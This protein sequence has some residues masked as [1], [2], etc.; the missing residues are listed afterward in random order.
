MFYISEQPANLKRE[1][2]IA[3]EGLIYQ[4]LESFLPGMDF[5]LFFPRTTPEN[6]RQGD[7]YIP[8]V[9]KDRALLPLVQ[10]KHLLGIVV[11]KKKTDGDA[12]PEETVLASALHL[13]VEN[14]GL[15]KAGETDHLTGLKNSQTFLS[16]I[17]RE[18]EQ[19]SAGLESGPN[20]WPENGS[21]A[22]FTVLVAD[23]DNLQS[24]NNRYSFSLGDEALVQAAECIRSLVPQHA[25]TARLDGDD[26]MAILLPNTRSRDCR[27]LA[28]SIIS[29]IQ[30][31]QLRTPLTQERLR[32]SGSIG[33]ASFPQ[34]IRG[35]RA[36]KG[37]MEI[38][39]QILEKAKTTLEYARKQGKNYCTFSQIL[40]NGAQI[41][42][43]LSLGRALI[44]IGHLTG[45][46]E[47][48]RFQV[49]PSFYNNHRENGAQ[50]KSKAQTFSPPKAE[51]ML[52]DVQEKESLAEILQ[53]NDP[54]WP[55]LQGD[56]L[57]L[58]PE[59]RELSVPEN[60]T[61]TSE[62][63][64]DSTTGLYTL[65]SFLHL[66][67]SLKSEYP[68]FSLIL[69]RIGDNLP[70]ADSKDME[71]EQIQC[72]AEKIRKDFPEESVG[73][74]YGS[75]SLIFLVPKYI[76]RGL[77][78]ACSALEKF[79][80]KDLNGQ[81][82][83]GIAT[84]PFLDFSRSAT[85]HNVR[86]ALEHSLLLDPPRVAELN[87]ISFNISADRLF[88]EGDLFSAIEEYK[89]SLTLDTEN[90]LARNS[91]GIC[92]AKLGMLQEATT[93][94]RKAVQR[95]CGDVM[96]WYNLGCACMRLNE[97]SEAQ[98]AFEKTLALDSE[99]VYSLFRLGQLAEKQ[100]LLD[101]AA[102]YYRQAG[103]NQRAGGIAPR[104]LARLAFKNNDLDTARELLHQ[105]LVNYPRDAHSLHLLS[106]IYLESGDDPEMAEILARQCSSLQPEKKE[107]LRTLARALELQGKNEESGLARSGA[108]K[109]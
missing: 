27:E 74:R 78:P 103:E 60:E 68:T 3:M 98:E 104:H 1:D 81:L 28:Q 49:H 76:P 8:L 66:W 79:C 48:Q 80:R 71:D 70:R 69:I 24:I 45:A 96:A 42:E 64:R 36:G 102:D 18:V 10:N 89:T 16:T 91:L 43:S 67:E 52:V 62:L 19:I 5:S 47:G 88:A 54:A 15:R 97:D 53:L 7:I 87:A 34:D 14:I 73:G 72:I 40:K 75:S 32:L 26:A 105:A 50:T 100:G 21:K 59:D 57:T 108:E 38:P 20:P 11:A 63:P 92:Y 86:K 35:S 4:F 33:I 13:C 101:K 12:I 99:Q 61:D 77:I 106:R 23:L 51:I 56:T 31:I 58:L 29:G 83:A 44:N 22:S 41:A 6:M 90:H 85:M 37:T 17:A 84:Y 9:E 2:L 107:Y 109:N 95:D 25:V 82:A 46:R 55:V 93:C 39:R 30:D 94:F 65:R